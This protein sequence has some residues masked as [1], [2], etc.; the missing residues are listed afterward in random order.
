MNNN[1]KVGGIFCDL[2][3]AFDCVD[4]KILLDKLEFYGIEGKFKTLIRSYLTD[5]HQRVVLGNISDSNNS[6]KWETIKCGVPQGSILGPLFFLFYINDLPKIINKDNNMVLYADDT[7]IIITD[8]NKLN[9]NTNLNQTFKDIITW[10][11]VNLLTLNFDKT[12]YLEFRT[13]NYYNITTQIKYDHKSLTNVT[14]TKFLGLIID[15]TLSWKQH[16]EQVI[17]KISSACYALRNI[18]YIVPLDTLKLIYFAHIHSTLN[19]GIIFW[20]NSPHSV[21]VFKM[22]KR[23]IRIITNSGN[24]DSCRKLFKKMEILPFYSQYL[25]TLIL[26]M[27]NNKHLFKANMDVHNYET[28]NKTN[29]HQP[30]AN[31]AKYY[32]GPYYF[33]IKVFNCLPADIKELSDDIKCFKNALKRFFHLHSFYSVEEYFNYNIMN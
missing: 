33:G 2:Q 25:Y 14:E 3:K 16:I 24:R 5:R 18:K 32:K 7:S 9:L 12:Q 26:Y 17:S 22:Q 23:I 29:L 19:Y 27:V 6:S 1:L 28:R 13:K 20:G 30:L 10:F 11:K 15:N 31:L 4:H 8:T 21:K